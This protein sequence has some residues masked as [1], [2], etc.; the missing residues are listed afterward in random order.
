MEQENTLVQSPSSPVRRHGRFTFFGDNIDEKGLEDP[1]MLKDASALSPLSPL[2]PHD[3]LQDDDCTLDDDTQ[4][5]LDEFE[6]ELRHSQTTTS[7]RLFSL[8]DVTVAYLLLSIVP[9]VLWIASFCGWQFGSH[10]QVFR[11]CLFIFLVLTAFFLGRVIMS[12][13]L[14]MVKQSQEWTIRVLY[15]LGP[16]EVYLSFWTGSILSFACFPILSVDMPGIKDQKLDKIGEMEQA[17]AMNSL[18]SIFVTFTCLSLGSLWVRI[19]GISFHR[20]SHHNRIIDCLMTEFSVFCF[21]RDKTEARISFSLYPGDKAPQ[22]QDNVMDILPVNARELARGAV[23]NYRLASIIESFKQKPYLLCDAVCTDKKTAEWEKKWVE[24]QS[25]SS[26]ERARETQALARFIFKKLRQNGNANV[27]VADFE[28]YLGKELAQRAFIKFVNGWNGRISE[29]DLIA[30][31]LDVMKERLSICL[32]LRDAQTSLKQLE[33][34]IRGIAV[35]VSVVL[36]AGFFGISVNLILGAMSAFF[37]TAAVAMGDVMKG[38][39]SSMFFLFISHPFD[40]GDRVVVNGKFYL[41][42][43]VKM[44]STVMRGDDNSMG[45]LSL[46]D[47]L[48]LVFIFVSH[49]AYFANSVLSTSHIINLR[50]S[51]DQYDTILFNLKQS[52]DSSDPDKAP[53]FLDNASPSTSNIESKFRQFEKLYKHQIL[54]LSHDYYPKCQV[55]VVD[56]PSDDSI[57]VSIQIQHRGNFQNMKLFRAKRTRMI[58]RVKRILEMLKLEYERVRCRAQFEGFTD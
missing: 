47:S 3:T 15:Y 19:F 26:L 45:K 7:Y 51:P 50:R 55:Q 30:S 40:I 48:M 32:S 53:L 33:A 39:L 29:H 56:S 23:S 14:Y 12:L 17:M 52:T 18:L 57:N 44:L 37:V 13:I 41:V 54:S 34:F 27:T 22:P 49:I 46:S 25:R 58:F 20:S 10:G 28:Q 31:L 38:V 9:V 16:L 5:L 1:A 43:K 35:L 2:S 6:E 21:T 42:H 36:T 11:Y 24:A 4:Q 8:R